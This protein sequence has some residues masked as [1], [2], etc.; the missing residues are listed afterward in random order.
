MRAIELV[1]RLGLLD[2]VDC[3]QKSLGTGDEGGAVVIASR[4]RVYLIRV[5]V[6][7]ERNRGDARLLLRA[8]IGDKLLRHRACFALPNS[9]TDERAQ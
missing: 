9:G 2:S 5:R 1:G 8:E 7:Y 3:F 6:E 4:K